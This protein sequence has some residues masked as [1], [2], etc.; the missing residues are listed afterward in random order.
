MAFFYRNTWFLPEEDPL[1]DTGRQELQSWNKWAKKTQK[2]G[3]TDTFE[4]R[5]GEQEPNICAR[6]KVMSYLS[7]YY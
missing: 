2:N 1:N 3:R 5:R 6:R 7:D 4:G